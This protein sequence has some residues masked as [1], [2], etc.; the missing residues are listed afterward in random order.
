M[1]NGFSFNL[2]PSTLLIKYNSVTSEDNAYDYV[3]LS[4]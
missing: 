1:S 4:K 3:F 2:K